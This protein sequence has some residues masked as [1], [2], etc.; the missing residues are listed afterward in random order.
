MDNLNEYMSKFL[1]KGVHLLCTDKNDNYNIKLVNEKSFICG[2]FW[3]ISGLSASKWNINQEDLKKILR[4]LRLCIKTSK[5]DEKTGV[6]GDHTQANCTN[7]VKGFCE[8]TDQNLYETNIQSTL[9]AI[10]IYYMVKRLKQ[11][12]KYELDNL[13]LDDEEVECV[14]N[15]AKQLYDKKIGCFYNVNRKPLREYNGSESVPSTPFGADLR[16]TMA[17]LCTIN[18]CYKILGYSDEEIQKKIENEMNVELIYRR[19]K[20]HFNDDGGI[21]L[22]VGGESNVAGCFCCIGSMI[23]IKRL[24]S[25]STSRIRRLVLWLLER[26]SISGG[27]SGR[28]GKSKDICYMWWNLATLTLIRG[29]HRKATRL[30]NE[31]VAR[32]MLEFIAISQNEDGGFSCNKSSTVSDPYHSFT[33][34]LSIS[35]LREYLSTNDE[36]FTDDSRDGT[37]DHTVN[38]NSAPAVNLDAESGTGINIGD[39]TDP[40]GIRFNRI[41]VEEIGRINALYAIPCD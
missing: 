17:A 11:F 33:A 18:L 31:N 36:G 25:L 20:E 16:H 22:Q 35:L 24:N 14:V 34:I 7:T 32:K 10:Q 4:R 1:I 5:I 40:K 27:V 41:C 38:H 9:Y 13:L 6:K 21:A 28:V 23:L 3:A 29:N 2:S 15:Y 8:F 26:I 19:L 37:G 39:S 30:F 12:E